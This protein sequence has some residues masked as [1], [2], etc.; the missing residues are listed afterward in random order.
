[1]ASGSL[2]AGII[3]ELLTDIPPDRLR[4]VEPGGVCLLN[5][6]DP[7]AASATSPRKVSENLVSRS[8]RPE[9]PAPGMAAS[10]R[11]SSSRAADRR[12]DT[13]LS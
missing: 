3:E 1:M 4:T 11:G 5:L 10:A 7:A 6:D 13:S 9:A 2:R 12:L 8:R